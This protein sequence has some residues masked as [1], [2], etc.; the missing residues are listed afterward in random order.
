MNV[1]LVGGTQLI[2]GRPVSYW[3]TPV[4][5][6]ADGRPIFPIGGGAPDPDDDED[7]NDDDLDDG[8][9]DDEDDGDDEDLSDAEKKLLGKLEPKL[10]QMGQSIADR[11]INAQR[12]AERK[13]QRARERESRTGSTRGSASSRRA[14]EERERELKADIRDGRSAFRDAIGDTGVKFTDAE[15]RDAAN[16]MGRALVEAAVRGGADPDDAGVDAAKQVAA[17]FKTARKNA[18][19]SVMARLERQGVDVKALQKSTGKGTQ[20]GRGPK[21]TSTETQIRAG[22][23]RAR[24]LMPGRVAQAQGK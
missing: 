12:T 18:E 2:G 13:A 15:E 3:R 7:D 19:S 24:L 11:L 6:R 4:G 1:K 5:F 14:E 22:E 16:R 20:P 10:Q 8:G 9:D 23:E 17:V 21:T